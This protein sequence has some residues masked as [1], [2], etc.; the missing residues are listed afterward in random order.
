M[1]ELLALPIPTDGGFEVAQP[2][3]WREPF[4]NLL[5]LPNKTLE[6][7]FDTS[8][9]SPAISNLIRAIKE[10]TREARER[11]SLRLALLNNMGAL[12]VDQISAFAIAIWDRVDPTRGLPSDTG[13]RDNAILS[14]P[15]AE[16]RCARNIYRAYVLAVD[17]PM[18]SQRSTDADGKRT[19]TTHLNFGDNPLVADLLGATTPLFPTAEMVHKTIDWSSDEAGTL[20][21][22]AVAW[23]DNDKQG[24]QLNRETM[25]G[26]TIKRQFLMLLA[27]LAEVILP[28]G[29]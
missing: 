10:G 19:L 15:D 22:K 13:L 28:T 27:L 2:Q 29:A 7:G 12:T 1:T 26:D 21:R 9:W 8:A 23:W 6:G 16:G 5:W 3:W 14:L 11:A 18:F 24:F 17:F 4:S 25:F 20:L